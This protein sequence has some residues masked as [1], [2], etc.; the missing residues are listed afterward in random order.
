M[1]HSRRFRRIPTE[2]KR[3]LL[4]FLALMMLAVTI[5]AISLTSQTTQEADVPS[6]VSS[7]LTLYDYPS[8]ELSYLTIQRGM[9]DAWTAIPEFAT[10]LRIYGE[11]SYL[12]SEEESRDLFLAACSITVEDVLTEDPAVYA[13]HL[14]DYGLEKPAYIATIGYTD[15]TS[16]TL[17]VGDEGPEGTWRYLLIDGDDRLFA[18]SNGSVE[19]LFVN[20]DTLRKISQP[21]LHK[22]RI[23]RITLTQPDSCIQWT[24][25]GAITDADAA[26]KWRITAPIVYPADAAAMENLL[27]NIANLRL[28]AYVC[29]A[30]QDNLALY[31]FDAPRLT[32]DIHMAE[33]TIGVTNAEGAVE[34][35]DWPDTTLTFVIGGAKNDMVDYILCQD[36]IYISSH[37]TM[38]MFIDYDYSATMSRYPVLTA[39]GNLASLHIREGAAATEYVLTRTEQV[40][41]NNALITDADGNP[42][43]DVRV[44]CNGVS[45]DYAAFTAAYNDLSLVTVSG[46]L[47]E[48]ET[49]SSAPHTVYTFTDVDGSVH[50][51]ALATFDALHDAVIVDGHAAFYL[52]KGG[53]RLNLN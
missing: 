43:Y 32:I 28:G 29:P 19:A 30:T 33:G 17:H 16:L 36:A 37:F 34:T 39:L 4:L 18:F 3:I 27:S 44:A 38:G 9:E 25:D 35:T 50:T 6:P 48:G 31:G 21:T 8:A 40:A 47:P 24:L 14:A 42:V 13:G 22:A 45:I 49:I 41:E 1:P 53:F 46:R 15:G 5:V 26:D 20:K 7:T 51:V 52:I 23:D 12:L 10:Q 11:D 2:K